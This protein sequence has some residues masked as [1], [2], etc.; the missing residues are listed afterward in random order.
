MTYRLVIVSAAERDLA[1]L[2]PPVARRIRAELLVLA[3]ATDP[4]RHLK[5]LKGARSPPFFSLR[6]GD[7][8]VILQVLD[9]LLVIVVVEVGHRSTVYRDV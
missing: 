9:D 3:A 2:D 5:R 8:R 7:Y 1:R 6:V 4:W